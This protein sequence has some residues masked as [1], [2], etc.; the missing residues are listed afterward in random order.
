MS[1]FDS[2]R[3][4]I[5]EEIDRIAAVHRIIATFRQHYGKSQP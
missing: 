3:K 1:D 2:D 4:R 5:V